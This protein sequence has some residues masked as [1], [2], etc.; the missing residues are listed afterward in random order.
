MFTYVSLFSSAGVGCFGLKELGFKCIATAE[1]LEKRINIQKY[2]NK[3]EFESGYICGD[4]TQPKTHDALYA[5]INAYKHLKNIKDVDLVVATPPCQGMSVANHKKNEELG[6]N[7]LVVES[8]RIVKEQKPRFFIFE[9]VRA[10]LKSTCT[11]LDG[12]DKPINEAIHTNLA[13]DY[14]IESKVL[15][16]KTMARTQ[17]ELAP[18]LLVFDAIKK[19]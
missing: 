15:N 8:L 5:E 9:N 11:D 17:V 1:L 19:A 3:C 16:L 6:R 18:W 14:L 13:P 12:V 2:N 7:S 4:L 10:F